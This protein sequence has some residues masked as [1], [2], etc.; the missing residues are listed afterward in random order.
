MTEPDLEARYERY[1]AA[2]ND[3]D[4][5][6]V[7]AQFAPDAS[8]EDPATDGALT[9]AEIGEFVAETVEAFPD[10]RFEVRRLHVLEE[11]DGGGVVTSEWTMHGTHEGPLDG[12]PAT[13]E[14]IALEGMEVVE[15]SE[16]GITAIRGCFN[17]SDVTEQLGLGF[18][19]VV[20]KLP[21]LA[22]GAVRNA[23]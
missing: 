20:G 16:A 19:A 6:A 11:H 22:A 12:L 17:E 8:Y 13:G 15:F 23:L 9:R 21:T 1:V 10:V 7:T 4:P 2:W 14:T 3:H 5:D 18:P